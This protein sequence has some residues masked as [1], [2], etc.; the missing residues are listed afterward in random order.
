MLAERTRTGDH[1]TAH[2]EGRRRRATTQMMLCFAGPSPGRWLMTPTVTEF[3]L[4]N[5][6]DTTTQAIVLQRSMAAEWP[7]GDPCPTDK[8]TLNYVY[9]RAS[10]T[11]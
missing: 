9:R 6:D 11:A 4:V 2:R 10:T 1:F 3:T 7:A 8:E 5:D